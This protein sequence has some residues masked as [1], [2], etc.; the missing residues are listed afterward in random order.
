MLAYY[1][2]YP[3]YPKQ[4][5]SGFFSLLRW[6]WVVCKF[7]S[8]LLSSGKKTHP[9]EWL[10]SN[11]HEVLIK[12]CK[13][14]DMWYVPIATRGGFCPSMIPGWLRKKNSSPN[15]N[16][17]VMCTAHLR[18]ENAYH[19]PWSVSKRMCFGNPPPF[20]SSQYASLFVWGG[21]VLSTW[22]FKASF[23]LLWD[24]FVMF[25][26]RPLTLKF[27]SEH[28]ILWCFKWLLMTNVS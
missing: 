16:R 21:G 11:C 1:N 6:I 9:P 18:M 24:C 14:C 27:S 8:L 7:Q 23:V 22:S 26:Y 10:E 19:L 13:W 2:P 25:C 20:F 4:P 5:G 17:F 28:L 3:I 12:N 15:S